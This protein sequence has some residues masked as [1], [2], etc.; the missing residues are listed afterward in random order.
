MLF[1]NTQLFIIPFP[2]PIKAKWIVIGYGA[3]ELYST[4]QNQPGDNVAHLAHLGGMLFGF[5]L[6][7]MWKKDRRNFY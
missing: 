6:I 4:W 5:F 3:F 2:F 1:P 7:K